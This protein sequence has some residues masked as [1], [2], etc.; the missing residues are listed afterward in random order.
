MNEEQFHGRGRFN[1][2][3]SSIIAL[4]MV[5][6]LP[7]KSFL[8]KPLFPRPPNLDG[9][10]PRLVSKFSLAGYNGSFQVT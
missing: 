6:F 7:G 5:C 8:A 9:L 10:F 4:I 1:F 2:L 3:F